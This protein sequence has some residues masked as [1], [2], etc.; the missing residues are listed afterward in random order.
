[1]L[2][3]TEALAGG[4]ENEGSR[5]GLIAPN[6]R[7]TITTMANNTKLSVL[8][9]KIVE[10]QPDVRLTCDRAARLPTP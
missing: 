7:V 10:V 6:A 3:P 2:P 1:M 4:A 5:L 8:A 9:G